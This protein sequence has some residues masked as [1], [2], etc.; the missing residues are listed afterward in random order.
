[1]N[2]IE[3]FLV[4]EMKLQRMLLA[5]VS[6]QGANTAAN[7]KEKFDIVLLSY[8]IPLSDTPITIDCG[9]NVIKT[10]EVAPRLKYAC[11]RLNTV[12]QSSWAELLEKTY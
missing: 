2:V 8:N 6:F 4:E 10:T 3:I 5:F 9:S 11:H 7:I 12:V 1:M